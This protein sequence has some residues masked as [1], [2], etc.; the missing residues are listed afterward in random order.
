[1]ASPVELNAFDTGG[2][3]T[4]PTSSTPLVEQ[5]IPRSS[6]ETLGTRQSVWLEAGTDAYTLA[7]KGT[8][9]GT[10]ILAIEEYRDDGTVREVRFH[11]T[12]VQPE[13]RA[14]VRFTQ[15][16]GLR[17][18]IDGTIDSA[19]DLMTPEWN[20][21]KEAENFKHHAVVCEEALTVFLANISRRSG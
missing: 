12:S 4:G 2:R 16:D 8:G 14:W 6:F 15:L 9:V 1:M 17:M 19:S 3:H 21:E 13:S 10:F 7:I 11:E 5:G 20:A 18:E